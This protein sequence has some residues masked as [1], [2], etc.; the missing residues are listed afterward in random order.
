MSGLLTLLGLTTIGISG[1]KHAELEGWSKRN[2]RHTLPNGV[3]Y[4]TDAD[5][6]HR[7]VSNGALIF[8]EEYGSREKVIE[9]KSRRVVYDRGAEIDRENEK[10]EQITKQKSLE[11][12]NLLYL[13]LNPRC[14]KIPVLF[15]F[16]TGKQLA[17]ISKITYWDTKE[18]E[19]RKYYFYDDLKESLPSGTNLRY[20]C[21]ISYCSQKHGDK[22]VVITE[23]EFN[24]IK[25][26]YFS[27]K[28]SDGKFEWSGNLKISDKHEYKYGMEA[29]HEQ[30][31]KNQN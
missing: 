8:W 4:Y 6:R 2:L 25:K 9:I 1:L 21:K 26:E 3:E 13:K 22:G 28:L 27:L 11:N 18:V 7:L 23:E 15:E 31:Q 5:G 24:K 19:Y 12:G 29:Y 20:A 30:R 10:Q 14:G 16:K 17:E